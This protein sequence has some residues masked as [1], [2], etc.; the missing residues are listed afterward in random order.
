MS[1]P[2]P[3]INKSACPQHRTSIGLK[4]KKAESAQQSAKNPKYRE[5]SQYLS[6]IERRNTASAT[7]VLAVH[8]VLSTEYTFYCT[9]HELLGDSVQSR[10]AVS[11]CRSKC[12]SIEVLATPPACECSIS[13]VSR[14]YFFRTAQYSY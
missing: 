3:P 10:T 11:L 2:L 7:T 9:P 4:W 1:L 13:I 8:R 12:F 14:I 6:S 5:Y